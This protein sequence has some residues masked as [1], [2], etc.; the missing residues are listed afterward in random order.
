MMTGRSLR[1]KEQFYQTT[2]LASL[3]MNTA[4]A[5]HHEHRTLQGHTDHGNDMEGELMVARTFV[6][7]ISISLPLLVVDSGQNR[8]IH[9]CPL[10]HG[11]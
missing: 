7:P 4:G 11:A 9:C 1:W 6:A 3:Q 2:E 10:V 5:T 8:V